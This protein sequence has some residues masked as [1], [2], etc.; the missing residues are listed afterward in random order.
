MP[1]VDVD[2]ARI[3]HA[4]EFAAPGA[5]IGAGQPHRAKGVVAARHHDAA[6]RQRGKGHGREIA[7]ARRGAPGR[8]APPAAR[9]RCAP[10]P[11]RGRCVVAMQPRLWAAITTGLGL[12]STSF[13]S[14]G[15]P[16]GAGRRD[17]VVL[18]HAHR[19]LHALGPQALPMAGAGV[20][21][22]GHDDD[23]RF[24][25][26][27]AVLVGGGVRSRKSGRCRRV[28]GWPWSSRWMEPHCPKH[29]FNDKRISTCLNMAFFD[30]SRLSSSQMRAAPRRR[31]SRPGSRSAAHRRHQRAARR[32]HGVADA[33]RRPP[34]RQHL[35]QPAGCGSRARHM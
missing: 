20:A 32:E 14:A 7:A 30:I 6:V 4:N 18:H 27:P 11:P 24:A 26:A 1:R 3:L 34:A 2:V 31:G 13:S 23:R 12:S 28:A 17:P 21:P 16:G 35:D 25:H 5:G 9:R 8:P 33:R 19:A 22:A 10:R 15:H 29:R